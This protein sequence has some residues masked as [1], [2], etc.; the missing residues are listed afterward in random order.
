MTIFGRVAFFLTH[1]VQL[2]LVLVRSILQLH[3]M[4]FKRMGGAGG[5]SISTGM[6][7]PS[8]TCQPQSV[9]LNPARPS[10]SCTGDVQIWNLS[11]HSGRTSHGEDD[12][13]HPPIH[14]C[15][16]PEVLL[17]QLL[18]CPPCCSCIIEDSCVLLEVCIPGDQLQSCTFTNP[19]DT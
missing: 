12:L 16:L 8:T 6:S 17:D 15:K 4:T 5:R 3:R 11:K 10:H 18:Q 14:H 19:K 9:G 7:L 1:P 2:H 13:Y